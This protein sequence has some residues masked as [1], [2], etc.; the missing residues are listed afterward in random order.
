M[1]LPKWNSIPET[2]FKIIGRYE[3]RESTSVDCHMTT[4]NIDFI[5]GAVPYLK[6]AE[7]EMEMKFWQI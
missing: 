1:T 3:C 6:N 2:E 5:S 4:Q 7:F